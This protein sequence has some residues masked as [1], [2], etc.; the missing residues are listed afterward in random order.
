MADDKKKFYKNFAITNIKGKS[1]PNL[2]N[3]SLIKRKDA[4]L[5][6]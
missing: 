3:P 5:K 1:S 6:V 4:H 2:K